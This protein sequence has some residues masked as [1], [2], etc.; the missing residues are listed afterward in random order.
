MPNFD[1]LSVEA[2]LKLPPVLFGVIRWKK[3]IGSPSGDPCGGFRIRVEERTPSEFRAG[4]GGVIEKIPG[5]GTW[6]LVTDSASCFPAPDEGDSHVVRFT[7]RDVHLNV[8][9]GVYRV[10]PQLTGQWDSRGLIFLYLF[11]Y[12]QMDPLAW[13]VALRPDA[14]MATVEFEVVRRSWPGSLTKGG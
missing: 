2:V 3:N 4:P 12:R 13:Y 6:N 1:K 11:G 10:S 9:D 5:T 8:L 7:V 14:H